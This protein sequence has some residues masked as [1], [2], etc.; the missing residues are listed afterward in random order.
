VWALLIALGFVGGLVKVAWGQADEPTIRPAWR[1]AKLI[2]LTRIPPRLL[3]LD[4]AEDGIVL[5]REFE[6]PELAKRFRIAA[7]QLKQK[8]RTPNPKEKLK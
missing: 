1:R 2:R 6:A 7:T 8:S 3:K 4:Q 5:S